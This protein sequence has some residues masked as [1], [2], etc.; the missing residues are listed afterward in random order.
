MPGY[1]CAAGRAGRY[2]GQQKRGRVGTV[3]SAVDWRLV[4]SPRAV[5]IPKTPDA[6]S[7]NPGRSKGG[8]ASRPDGGQGG[9]PPGTGSGSRKRRASA[10]MSCAH[11][12]SAWAASVWCFETEVYLLQSLMDARIGPLSRWR[13]D[14]LRHGFR[15]LLSDDAILRKVHD[16]LSEVAAI[17]AH[18]P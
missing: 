9:R 4:R 6:V 14:P 2:S 15:V 11:G 13:R 1:S 16:G 12:S 8:C 10:P 17:V 18:V 7:R 5:G 3:G